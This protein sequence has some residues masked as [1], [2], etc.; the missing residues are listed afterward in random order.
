MEVRKK[1]KFITED[2]SSQICN[3]AI[4]N[5]NIFTYRIERVIINQFQFL[6]KTL[7]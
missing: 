2:I 7:E 5:S 6:A 4:Q 1:M 3:Q